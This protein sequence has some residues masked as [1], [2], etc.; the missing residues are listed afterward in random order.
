MSNNDFLSCELDSITTAA[1]FGIISAEGALDLSE[2]I[3]LF[4]S[5]DAT[6]FS[7][8]AVPI[9]ISALTYSEYAARGFN[10]ENDFN[11]SIIPANA[12]DGELIVQ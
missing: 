8:G 5:I 1:V 11:P 12:A 9:K 3:F 4:F 10:I 6:G 7:Y 2:D